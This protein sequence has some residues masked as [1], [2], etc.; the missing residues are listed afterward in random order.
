MILDADVRGMRA[1]SQGMQA[2]L[3]SFLKRQGNSSL[4]PPEGVPPCWSVLDFMPP[5]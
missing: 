4:E 1:S 2:V 5:N 3:R